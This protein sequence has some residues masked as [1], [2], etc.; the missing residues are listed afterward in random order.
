MYMYI[1]NDATQDTARVWAGSACGK[2]TAGG[3]SGSP[4]TWVPAGAGL[5]KGSSWGSVGKVL[6]SWEKKIWKRTQHGTWQD[7][8]F[9]LRAPLECLP[10]ARDLPTGICGSW[11]PAAMLCPVSPLLGHV[12]LG[13]GTAP[14][15]RWSNQVLPVL[16]CNPER[17]R[18]KGSLSYGWHDNVWTWKLWEAAIPPTICTEQLRKSVF[19]EKRQRQPSS[20]VETRGEKEKQHSPSPLLPPSPGSCHFWDAAQCSH[21]SLGSPNDR[22]I[23]RRLSLF[24]WS[25]I[26]FVS[27]AC[28]QRNFERFRLAFLSLSLISWKIKVAMLSHR[29]AE[30]IKWT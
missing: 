13:Q 30:R 27:V 3:V 9:M 1:Y 8:H 12:W 4:S 5:L 21:V 22:C 16:M 7:A 11:H 17:G 20:Q 10:L 23:L 19:R 18:Q 29:I 24:R 15:P 26:Q 25:E 2:S 14:N 28:N 6:A